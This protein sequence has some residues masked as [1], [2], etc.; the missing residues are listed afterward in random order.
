VLRR[1]ALGLVG[2]LLVSPAEIV[3]S[4]A[5]ERRL[6]FHHTHT[7]ERLSVVYYADGM[8]IESS[9]AQLNRLLRDHRTDEVRPIDPELF[10]FLD[11]VQRAT[12]GR[13]TYEVISGYRSPRTNAML[14]EVGGGGVAR[15]SQH[16]LGKAIDVR[17]SDVAT[18]E[19]R[20]AAL[21]LQRGGVGYYP[22]SDFVHLD[23]GRI[24][25]W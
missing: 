19:L 14:R 3:A 4:L 11:E 20:D 6:A 25:H 21:H 10:D 16:V 5:R 18:R 22:K 2:G 15:K 24:R 17:L 7:G 8:Y 9:L 1:L 12:G 23:T 13:G